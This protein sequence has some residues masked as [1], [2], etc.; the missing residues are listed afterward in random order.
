MNPLAAILDHNRLNGD[1]Y[2]DWKRNLHIVLT[3]EKLQKVLTDPLTTVPL[4]GAL[5]EERKAYEAWKASDDLAKC[6][7]LASME[8]VLQQQH[9]GME[10][11]AD[12]MYNLADM[13]ANQGW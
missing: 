11:A 6:Y 1:N 9:V 10:T 3:T 5:E 7:I 8:N 12:M 13:F 4:E 2:V